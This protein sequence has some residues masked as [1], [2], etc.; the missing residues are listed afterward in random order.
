MS[1]GSLGA[2]A[3][4]TP[5]SPPRLPRVSSFQTPPGSNEGSIEGL[6]SAEEIEMTRSSS[7]ASLTRRDQQPLRSPMKRQLSGIGR[8]VRSLLDLFNKE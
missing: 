1:L 6:P 2:A 3:P 4:S 7:G 8:R 5:Q